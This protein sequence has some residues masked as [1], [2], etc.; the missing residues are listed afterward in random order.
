VGD[1]YQELIEAILAGDSDAAETFC[2]EIRPKLLSVAKSFWTGPVAEMVEDAIQDSLIDFLAHIRRRG[3]FEG[4]AES[5]LIIMVKNRCI[6]LLTLEHL[7]RRSELPPN[8]PAGGEDAGDV[9]DRML[10]R[11]DARRLREGLDLLDPFCKDL[12]IRIYFE[13]VP[14][15]VLSDQMGSKGVWVI[16]EQRNKCLRSL[17]FLLNIWRESRFANESGSGRRGRK[18][19]GS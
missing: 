9:V 19:K 1:R 6:D 16:Y 8:A 11:L 15:K 7:D 18:S 14:V 17:A 12:L 10:R 13:D 2:A 5:Y 3:R 4:R